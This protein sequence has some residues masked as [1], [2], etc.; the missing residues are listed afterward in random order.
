MRKEELILKIDSMQI[1]YEKM[2]TELIKWWDK[3]F[4]MN[5]KQGKLTEKL[6]L[7][8]NYEYDFDINAPK[9]KEAVERN[10]I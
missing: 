2:Y 8:H 4:E 10:F 5:E 7:K 9:F 6:W 3:Y 1:E